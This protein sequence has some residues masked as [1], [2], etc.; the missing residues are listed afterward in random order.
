MVFKRR[1]KRPIWKSLIEFFYPR[2][3]WLRAARYVRHRLHRLPDPPHKISRGIWA[4][5]FTA[6]TPF[7]GLHFV[8]A[9]IVAFVMQGNLLAALLATFFG[10]PLTYVPIAVVSLKTGHWLLGTEFDPDHAGRSLGGKFADA[11]H[12]LWHNIQAKFTGADPDWSN[13]RVFFD[14]VFYP[15]MIGG[16]IPGIVA[17]SVCYYLAVPVIRVYQNRRKGRLKSKLEAIK[18]KRA[19]AKGEHPDG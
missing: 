1:D 15:Y 14:E 5:V 13:L 9:A 6:F 4:G 18:Q 11:G 3:G 19:A 17:A 2:G 8:V 10:N 12:D 16:I 7:Y